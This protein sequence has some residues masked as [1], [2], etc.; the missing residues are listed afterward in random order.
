MLIDR[1]RTPIHLI[2]KSSDKVLRKMLKLGNTIP[3][4]LVGKLTD[5]VLR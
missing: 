2:G 5:K 4:H 1:D 3:V